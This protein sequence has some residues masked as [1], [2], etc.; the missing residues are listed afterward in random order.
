M[1]PIAGL[2]LW[3]VY[4]FEIGQVDG[5]SFSIPAPTYLSNFNAVYDHIDRGH[6]ATLLGE[7]SNEGWWYYFGVAFLAKTPAVTVLLL[8]VTIVFITRHAAWRDT[9]YLWLPALALFVAASYSRLNIGYRHILPVIPLIWLLIAA[10]S[11]QWRQRR[12]FLAL[13]GVLLLIYALG[14]LGQSPDYLAYFNEFV[15][16][17]S[18]GYRYLGDSNI[19]WGQDLNQLAEYAELHDDRPLSIS[20]SGAS[21]PQYYGLEI[22]SLFSEEGDPL[23]FSPANPSPGRYAISVN[24]LQD[25]SLAEPDL[26]DWFRRQEP[27]DSLGYSILIYDVSSSDSGHWIAQCFDPEPPLEEAA[28]SQYVGRE[29]ERYIY[30]DCRNSWVLPSGSGPGWY[31]VPEDLDPGH[32]S[33]L[34]ADDL[35]LVFTNRHSVTSPPYKIYYWPA[36]DEVIVKLLEG[37]GQVKAAGTGALLPPLQVDDIAKFR[38][39]WSNG[40]VW[41]TLWQTDRATDQPVSVLLHLHTGEDQPIV[42]DNLGYP[43]IQWQP[44][45]LFIQYH[46]FGGLSGD[47][48]ETGLYNYDSGDRLKIDTGDG[49]VSSIYLIPSD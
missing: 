3:A 25:A 6:Y 46:D 12:S 38:G 44:G 39:G 45:D 17:S 43:G 8:L 19:D 41:S 1:L 2:V 10:S 18:Q 7:R 34:L 4:G 28:A 5:L 22:S 31:V 29:I 16:G 48:L 13:L 15:G 9:I 37:S 33:E 32:I 14:S 35:E 30:F 23:N 27:V 40:S 49:L 11:S 24:H 42:A 36:P 20:Y 21:D 47:Y 26:F